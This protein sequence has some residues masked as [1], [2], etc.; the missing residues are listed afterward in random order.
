MAVD[1]FVFLERYPIFEELEIS[2][3]ETELLLNSQ[4]CHESIWQNETIRETAI[5]LLSA[6]ALAIEYYDQIILGNQLRMTEVGT[7]IKERDL[8]KQSYFSLTPYGV[9]FAHLQQQILGLG[10]F[11][12]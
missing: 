12:P 2:I 11:V 10:I 5:Y 3:I 6:H 7:A 4:F 8:S 1:S 9:R